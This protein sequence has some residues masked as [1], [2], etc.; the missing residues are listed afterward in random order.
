MQTVDSF[1][2]ASQPL[3]FA[4]LLHCPMLKILSM[5][6]QMFVGLAEKLVGSQVASRIAL[7]AFSMLQTYL[8]I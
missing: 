4:C 6:V 5:L 1:W 8:S 7:Q 3:A 2:A